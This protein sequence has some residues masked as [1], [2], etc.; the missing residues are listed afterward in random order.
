MRSQRHRSR[1][2]FSWLVLLTCVLT[3]QILCWLPKFCQK[4]ALFL[5]PFWRHL[6]RLYQC[7]YLKKNW[8]VVV[9]FVWQKLKWREGEKGWITWLGFNI[10]SSGI[11]FCRN[12]KKADLLRNGTTTGLGSNSWFLPLWYISYTLPPISSVQIKRQKITTQ[13]ICRS[14][15]CF[16]GAAALDSDVCLLRRLGLAPAATATSADFLT[17][18]FS[19]KTTCTTH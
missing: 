17:W 11:H 8:S 5:A 13:N 1:F 15:C 16:F 9:H 18:I 4:S 2:V 3:R 14:G 6:S 19:S 12:F 7:H 10:H